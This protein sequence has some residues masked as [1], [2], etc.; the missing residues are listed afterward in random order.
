M[1]LKLLIFGVKEIVYWFKYLLSKCEDRSLDFRNLIY[2]L[3]RYGSLFIILVLRG[4]I[5]KISYV[6]KF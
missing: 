1:F 6:G 4:E 3:D 5:V 2:I